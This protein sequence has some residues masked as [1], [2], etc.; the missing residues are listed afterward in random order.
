[1]TGKR[2]LT[3][4]GKR[5]YNNQRWRHLRR[6]VLD[7]EPL[8]RAC[9]ARGIIRAA[10]VVDHIKPHRN[11]EALFWGES[12]LQPLCGKCHSIKT[13]SETRA[14]PLIPRVAKPLCPVTL[15]AGAPGSGKSWLVEERKG[16]MDLVIDLDQIVCEIFELPLHSV[17]SASDLKVA[18]VERNRRLAGLVDVPRSRKV[19]FIT[20]APVWSDR[21][22]WKEILGCET[23]V[24]ET[25][26]EVCESRCY[27]RP[28]GTDWNALAHEWWSRYSQGWDDEVIRSS[29]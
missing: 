14:V 15:V 4:S 3:E 1:M 27:G 7:H 22:L 2:L 18:M 9:G 20:M 16:P 10:E 19:W 17:L 25:P 12:N 6:R 5:L 28:E 11:D 13:A 21:K 8:C 23:V 26:P 24:V 29:S